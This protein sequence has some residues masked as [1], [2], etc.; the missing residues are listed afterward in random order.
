MS[1]TH[2]PS[3][4]LASASPRRHDI[5]TQLRIPHRVVV[6]P[7]PDG[8]DEPR[9]PGEAPRD[10]VQRT[11]RD[12]ALHAANWLTGQQGVPLQQVLQEA[13]ST[14][15]AVHKS[16]GI[17]D[18][19]AQKNSAEDSQQRLYILAADTTVAL[20]NDILGKPADTDEA[21]RTLARLSGQTHHV[22][23]AVA[24]YHNG[25]L[26]EALSTSVV[27]FK[28]LSDDEISAYCTT[29]E[30]MGKAGSYGIQGPAAAFV[31]YMEGSYTGIVGLPAYET[32]TLL[33]QVGFRV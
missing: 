19:H 26:A 14:G 2:R 1:V 28:P 15:A 31:E 6:P 20:G 23:T 10:Y 8:E 24:V 9:L 13:D 17:K 32:A 22:Y 21:A 11:A 33:T 29:G 5:L 27:R 7:S 30:P 18:G 16:C 12:K 3:L 25:H 4:I